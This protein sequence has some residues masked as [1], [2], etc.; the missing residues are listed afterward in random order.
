[1][2]DDNEP[3]HPAAPADV[4]FALSYGLRFSTTG[5]P[6]KLGNELA[7]RL[8]AEMLLK[9]LNRSGFVVM[10]RPARPSLDQ[11]I[12]PRREG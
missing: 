5:K 8:A 11:I 10:R 7:S 6:H 2:P 4:L 9:H 1:M 12:G 3:L